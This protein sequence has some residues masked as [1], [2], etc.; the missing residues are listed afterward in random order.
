MRESLDASDS[1]SIE[2]VP[3][4]DRG[5]LTFGEIDLKIFSKKFQES[6]TDVRFSPKR[7]FKRR[8]N[9][10]ID[11]PLSAISGRTYLSP[12]GEYGSGV[13]AFIGG[14]FCSEA[15]CSVRISPIGH[16]TQK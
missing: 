12:G 16:R 15:P 7:P 3:R 4:G 1:D 11:S 8:Q 5:A 14:S 2:G 13:P 6:G 10:P 9:H